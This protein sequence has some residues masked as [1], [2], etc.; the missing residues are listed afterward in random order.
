VDSLLTQSWF[1]FLNLKGNSGNIESFVLE[2][3]LRGI[4][5]LHKFKINLVNGQT[6]V[7]VSCRFCDAILIQQLIQEKE[8]R[9]TKDE[10]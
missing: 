3:I 1:A 8:R 10:G 2:K 7:V 9:G 4:F 5:T 6:S